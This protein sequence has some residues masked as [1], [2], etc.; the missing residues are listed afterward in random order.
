MIS[1]FIHVHIDKCKYSVPLIEENHKVI[2][3]AKEAFTAGVGLMQCYSS[4]FILESN[5]Y[6]V[7]KEYQTL[8]G[9]EMIQLQ[10]GSIKRKKNQ[11]DFGKTDKDFEAHDI[12]FNL[13]GPVKDKELE[14]RSSS[15]HSFP[16]LINLDGPSGDQVKHWTHKCCPYTVPVYQTGNYT[17]EACP[18]TYEVKSRST[19]DKGLPL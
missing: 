1:N 7:P 10:P 19:L 4:T 16:T 13:V 6:R 15:L 14:A 5:Y 12:I 17:F 11:E 18:I 9:S 3:K 8:L 2:F